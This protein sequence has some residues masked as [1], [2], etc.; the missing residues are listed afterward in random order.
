MRMFKEHVIGFSRIAGIVALI[1][2]INPLESVQSA[3]GSRL[4]TVVGVGSVWTGSFG[5]C[6]VPPT[7]KGEIRGKERWVPTY[8]DKKGKPHAFCDRQTGIVIQRTPGSPLQGGLMSPCN[9]GAVCNWNQARFYCANLTVGDSGQKG[10]RLMYIQELAALVDLNS[11]SCR[12]DNFCLPDRN[13]FNVQVGVYWSAS[14]DAASPAN[15]WDMATSAGL[16][17]SSNKSSNV[18]R[19]WCGRGASAADAY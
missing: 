12:E 3:N 16:V 11:K 4:G 1:L 15:A 6:A 19:A 8:I 17:R 18:L 7:W 14:T 5:K 13:P 2:L 10:W 9:N